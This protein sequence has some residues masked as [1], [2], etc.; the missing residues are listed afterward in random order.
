[1]GLYTEFV[2]FRPLVVPYAGLYISSSEVCKPPFAGS[3]TANKPA[4]FHNNPT[5]A[6]NYIINI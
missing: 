5:N 4:Q 3:V 1:M 6:D 2:L